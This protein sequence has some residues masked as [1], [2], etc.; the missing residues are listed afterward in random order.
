MHLYMTSFRSMIFPHAELI[1]SVEVRADVLF[2]G[3]QASHLSHNQSRPGEY[4]FVC[5][6]TNAI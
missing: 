6:L 2:F 4:L 5:I 3:K 1:C